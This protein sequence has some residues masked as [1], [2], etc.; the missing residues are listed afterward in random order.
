MLALMAAYFSEDGYAF[1]G[2]DARRAL[3]KDGVRREQHLATDNDGRFDVTI[4]PDASERE[5]GR[6]AHVNRKRVEKSN[7]NTAVISA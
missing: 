1:E 5:T 7:I 2:C 3:Y 6:S 4:A